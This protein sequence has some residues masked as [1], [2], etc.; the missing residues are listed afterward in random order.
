MTLNLRQ[1]KNFVLVIV[2]FLSLNLCAIAHED[3]DS[4]CDCCHCHHGSRPIKEIKDGSVLSI[5]DCISIGLK[6]SP[7][8]KKYKFELDVAKSNVGKAKSVYFPTIGA[9]VGYAQVNNSNSK[10]FESMYRELPFVGVALNKM[11]WDFGRSSANIKMEEFYKI[12]AEYEFMDSVCSTVFEI[13]MRYYDVL[14]AQSILEAQ[15]INLEINNKL[16]SD[17][18]KMIKDKKADETDLLNA[19][20]QKLKIESDILEA[21]DELLNAKENLNNSMYFVNAP[22][23]SIEETNTYSEFTNTKENPY[24]LVSNV[25]TKLK[26]NVSQDGIMPHNF[27]YDEAVEIAYR[28]SPD[29]K[30]LQA[31]KSAMEQALLAVKR[32]Y[33]PELSGMVG[34]NFLNSNHFANND[35]TVGVNLTSSL[36]PMELKYSLKGAVAQVELAEGALI[37]YRQNLYFSVR[38]ALNTVRKC[39]AQIPI[40]QKEMASA[41]DNL[42]RTLARYKQNQM[43]QL[44]LLYARN[45]YY[46]AM[47]DYIDSVYKYNIAL[48]HLE[49]AMHYHLVDIHERTEHAIKYH[50]EEIIDN[51]NNIMDCDKHDKK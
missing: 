25:S 46:S 21:T 20:I 3:G 22:N 4:H 35:L 19:E 11:I 34:Y 9:G 33:Y 50:D 18:K 26:G 44:E 28:N 49:I 17:I 45:T 36:N 1:I 23:Y 31:T 8:I 27:S 29:L 30:A 43:D 47:E 2:L 42:E 38:K 12:A 41:Y 39:K 15:K 7:I 32:S 5:Q 48:I 16:I 40:A 37:M 14:R 10:H 13:K 24:K 6:N 51:F